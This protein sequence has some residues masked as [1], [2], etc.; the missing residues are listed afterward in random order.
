MKP[1][2]LGVVAAMFASA[3]AP[4]AASAGG[5]LLPGSGAI[6]TSRAGAA[7]AS[8]D[9][10][11]ALSLT[12]AGLAKGQGTTIT[13]SAAIID[14]SMQFT[15]RGTYDPIASE[16]LP[17]EGQPYPTVTNEAKPPL[18]FGPFQPVPVIAIV[19]DLG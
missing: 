4:T 14:Y 7:I 2:E 19:S 9:D 3:G 17:Y 6:S 16:D 18:G 12:P 1:I 5:L 8:A 10:G 15:R 13:I 11:R